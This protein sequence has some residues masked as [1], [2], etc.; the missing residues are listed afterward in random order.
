[1]VCKRT[2]EIQSITQKIPWSSP[3]SVSNDTLSM[4]LERV[5]K[6]AIAL[7]QSCESTL[8][9]HKLWRHRKDPLDL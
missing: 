9:D 5:V 2:Y 4:M 7:L 3:W 1:M 8:L 6:F